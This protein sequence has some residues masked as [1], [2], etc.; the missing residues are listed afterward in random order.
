MEISFSTTNNICINDSNGLIVIESIN[1]EDSNEAFLYRNYIIIWSGNFDENT[2]IS[3]DGSVVEN[4]K[5]GVY[6]FKLFSPDS[7]QESQIYTIEIFSESSEIKIKNLKYLDYSC[8]DSAYIYIE[9]EGGAPPYTFIAGTNSILSNDNQAKIQNLTNGLYEVSVIDINGC[10]VIY[11]KI[12]EIKDHTFSSTINNALPPQLLNSYGLLDISVTGKGPFSFLFVDQLEPDKNI[13]VDTFETKYIKNIDIENNVYNYFFDDLI[14]PGTY[15]LTIKNSSDCSNFIDFLNIPNSSP[16][17]VSISLSNSDSFSVPNYSESLPIFDTLL[18][19]YKFIVNNSELWTYIKDK[20]IKDKIDLIVNNE[21]YETTITRNIL[22]KE[23]FNQG[24]IEILR[25]GNDP[26]DWFFYLYISPGI[27]IGSEPELLSSK[28]QIKTSVNTFDIT[29]GLNQDQLIDTNN[30]SIII[31][32]F[33]LNDLGYSEYHN[34][35]EINVNLSIP[36]SFEDQQFNVKNITKLTSLNTYS[37]GFVT[38]L[39]FLEQFDILISRININSISACNLSNEKYQYILNIKNLL[40]TINNFN[41]LNSIFIYNPLDRIYQGSISL[42][43]SGNDF[44][45]LFNNETIQ[46]EYFIEYYY[47]K[48]DS[49]LLYNIYLG[50][51]IIENTNIVNNLPEGFYIIKIKDLYKNIV[52]TINFQNNFID[53]DDHF[54]KSKK[55]I[56]KF[57]SNLLSSFNYG[58]ILIYIGQEFS[59]VGDNVF[60]EVINELPGFS[61]PEQPDNVVRFEVIEQTKD[62]AGTSSISVELLDQEIECQIHGPKN[63]KKT[64]NK[65]TSFT[66]LIPGVYTILGDE[67]SL[68]RASKYQNEIRI[69]LDKNTNKS[70]FVSFVSYADFIFIKNI[71]R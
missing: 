29:L 12:I 58:D 2:F 62:N 35:G 22:D 4:L 19:P 7:Q 36:S 67:D 71:D 57:N 23:C 31:G 5:N 39:N 69:F 17:G 10:T 11:D 45:T 46:N 59:S 49:N 26:E 43:I 40:K 21:K 9:V 3:T 47:I 34:G 64:F 18:I 56:Q 66:N 65:N 50:S 54:I 41:N 20:K 42:D 15:S 52:R 70:I 8:E 28:I 13:Y 48:N 24:D 14:T 38:I 16:I 53:Y 32:S 33:I 6:Q 63:Y 30:P 25:L 55:M 60:E 68:R 1:F 51:N 61:S 37:V 44:F 27:N